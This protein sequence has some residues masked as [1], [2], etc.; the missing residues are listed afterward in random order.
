VVLVSETSKELTLFSYASLS[1][2]VEVEARA[3]AAVLP[4]CQMV[5]DVIGNLLA[6]RRQLKQLVVDERIVALLGKFPT[7]GR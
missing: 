2:A 1:R 3:D 5:F 6:D 4:G 7:N